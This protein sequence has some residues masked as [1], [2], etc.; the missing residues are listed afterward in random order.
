M[1]PCWRPTWTPQ[2]HRIAPRAHRIASQGTQNCSPGT[3]I[4]PRA[5]ELH[6]STHICSRAHTIDPRTHKIAPRVH[7]C[8]PSTQNC[9]PSTQ[10]CPQAIDL[11][12]AFKM[13]R[14]VTGKQSLP[15]VMSR[16]YRLEDVIPIYN[17]PD[18][19]WRNARSDPPPK[20]GRRAESS[21]PGLLQPLASSVEAFSLVKFSISPGIWSLNVWNPS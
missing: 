2:A 7:S 10:N 4:G 5:T 21:N 1:D 13:I 11:L 12:V 17:I 8:L 19:A 15:R 18:L 16:L 6:P 20:S 9:S 14:M 3:R